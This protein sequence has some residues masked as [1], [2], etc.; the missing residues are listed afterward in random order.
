MFLYMSESLGFIPRRRVGSMSSQLYCCRIVL[1]PA[2]SISLALMLVICYIMGVK[3]V[4]CCFILYFFGSY[5]GLKHLFLFS[6]HQIS[7]CVNFLFTASA[8]CGEGGLL[9]FCFNFRNFLYEWNTNPL[10]YS[11][12]LP[13]S[14]F[15]VSFYYKTMKSSTTA[16]S[17]K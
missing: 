10:F 4:S 12:C 7:W 11:E 2:E 5:W 14:V 9:S 17:I 6:D 8:S 3:M 13:I 15:M 1:R 16:T